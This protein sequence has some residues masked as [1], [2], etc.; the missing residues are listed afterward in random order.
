VTHFCLPPDGG[1]P[2]SGSVSCSEDRSAHSAAITVA[3]FSPDGSRVVTGDASG[4]VVVWRVEGP[5][6][7]GAEG[8]AAAAAGAASAAVAAA[9]RSFMPIQ[10]FRRAGAV[11]EITFVA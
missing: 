9:Q 6:A 8:A 2:T 11:T 5:G 10:T 3:R 1:S 4:V 7:P